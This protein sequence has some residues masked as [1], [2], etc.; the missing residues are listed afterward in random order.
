VTDAGGFLALSAASWS[1]VAAVVTVFIYL[2]LLIFAVKQVRE[3]RRLREAQARPFVI[4]DFEPTPWL[5]QLVVRNIGQTAAYDVSMTFNPPLDS[6]MPP[7]HPWKES[8][9]F[10]EGI[11]LLPPHRKIRVDFD[12]VHGRYD[13]K[14]TLP[15][16]YQVALTYRG[17]DPRS[18]PHADHYVLDLNI[19][20]GTRFPEAGIPEIASAVTEVKRVIESSARRNRR[21]DWPGDFTV[22]DGPPQSGEAKTKVRRAPAKKAAK[23]VTPVEKATP[24]RATVAKEPTKRTPARKRPR[25]PGPHA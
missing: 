3:A 23:K 19:Y 21:Q 17:P 11:S 5:L 12:S 25:P 15:M 7:P 9:A 6:S 18:K 14:S 4:V 2:A 22:R 10:T 13:D 1:A 16:R 8:S 20:R 24:T